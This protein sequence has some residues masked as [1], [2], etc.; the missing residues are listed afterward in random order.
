LDNFSASAVPEPGTT[1]LVGMGLGALLLARRHQ[2][3]W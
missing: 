1:V 2:S 3:N